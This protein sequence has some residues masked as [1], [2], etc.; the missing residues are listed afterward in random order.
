MSAGPMS[1][2][3]RSA[4]GAFSG[5]RVVEH[6]QHLA[7]AFA[8]RLFAAMGAEVISVGPHAGPDAA[9][10]G[11][12][13]HLTAGK[14]L[15]D[16]DEST[17]GGQAL[18]AGLLD[19]GPDVWICDTLREASAVGA[20]PGGT[21]AAAVSDFGESGPRRD[22]RGS[23]MIHQALSGVMGQTGE[24]G[25]EPLFGLSSRAYSATGV[26]LF[27]S[28]VARLFARERDRGGPGGSPAPEA[29][30]EPPLEV[31]VTETAASMGQNEVATYGYSGTWP[32]RGRYPG[33]VGK[34]PC[35]DGWVVVFGLGRWD[36]I[37]RAFRC[38]Q[39][40]S[41]ER[42]ALV[43]DRIAHWQAALGALADAA[44][45]LTR[46]EIV[47][48]AQGE[49]ATVEHIN[50][51][52]DLRRSEHLAQR[53]FW[54]EGAS[55]EGGPGVALGPVFRVRSRPGWVTAPAR[56]AQ[57]GEIRGAGEP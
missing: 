48:A 14:R 13:W 3:P 39:L 19:S 25:R 27:G 4:A 42:F 22:W 8:G 10:D 6:T 12:Y 44:R 16:L 57:A 35:A 17:P 7:G 54:R 37:C 51:L 55:G 43:P 30:P 11:A 38:P 20:R 45:G 2:G 26:A 29:P 5:L 50:T 56:P 41:D 18:L 23:E 52:A 33:L 49:H 28:V 1:A 53:E 32:R 9:G 46:D 31:T 36:V 15:A 24:A 47:T 21:I 34:V 40:A